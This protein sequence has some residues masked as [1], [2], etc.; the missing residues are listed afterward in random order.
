MFDVWIRGD[1]QA[2]ARMVSEELELE[3]RRKEA[4]KDRKRK[5]EEAAEEN[6]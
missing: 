3:K 1:A 6:C 5:R 2:F 4:S